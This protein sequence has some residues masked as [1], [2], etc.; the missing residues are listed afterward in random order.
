MANVTSMRAYHYDLNVTICVLF[1]AKNG[2]GCCFLVG[3]I[4]NTF[5]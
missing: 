4:V 5:T 1:M 3:V 2:T